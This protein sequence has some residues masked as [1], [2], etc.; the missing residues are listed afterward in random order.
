M[1]ILTRAKSIYQGNHCSCLFVCLFV[2]VFWHPIR[3]TIQGKKRSRP[4]ASSGKPLGECQLAIPPEIRI[5]TP[6][7]DAGGT[8]DQVGQGLHDHCSYKTFKII[9]WNLP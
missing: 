8:N 2:V 3:D 1:Q 6:E 4:V 5:Y 9:Q 7:R